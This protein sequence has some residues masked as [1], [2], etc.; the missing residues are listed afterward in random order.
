MRDF[1]HV[2]DVARAN[3]LALEPSPTAPTPALRGLQRLLRASRSRSCDVA[4]AGGGGHRPRLAPEVTGG[5]RLG[6]VRHV[7][8]SP[9]RAGA[10]LGFTAADRARAGAAGVRHRSRLREP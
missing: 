7:V 6:D 5:Y 1:V 3:L 9:E 10:E 4:A 8:A 2:A